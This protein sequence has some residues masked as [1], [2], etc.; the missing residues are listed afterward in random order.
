MQMSNTLLFTPFFLNCIGLLNITALNCTSKLNDGTCVITAKRGQPVTFCIGQS[1]TP[2]TI[3]QGKHAISFNESYWS[4]VSLKPLVFSIPIYRCKNGYCEKTSHI[5]ILIYIYFSKV[6]DSCLTVS[7]EG[8]VTIFD[9][10]YELIVNYN[11]VGAI[12]L[13][14]RGEKFYVAYYEGM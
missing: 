5:S 12:H 11:T 4:V 7:I 3:P 14:P 6:S 8:G 10:L 2:S 1:T 9:L 13:P